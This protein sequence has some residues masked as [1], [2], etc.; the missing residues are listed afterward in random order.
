MLFSSM[1][2]LWVFLPIVI[3][4]NFL[5]ST[6]H[7]PKE[8]NRIHIKNTFL[9]LASILFYAWGDIYYLF[10]ML[11]SILLNYIS[12]IL[13][14]QNTKHKR[15][16]LILSIILNLGILF[17]FKYYTTFAAICQGDFY[18]IYK[19]SNVFAIF[20]LKNIMV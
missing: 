3:C 19:L 9:L 1:I 2:F 15:F 17:I 4:G 16:F 13:I 8:E 5:L 10:I 6:I 7:F 18:N 11:S 20:Y 14:D 12:G